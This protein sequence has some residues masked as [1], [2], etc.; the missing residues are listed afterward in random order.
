MVELRVG[1]SNLDQVIQ[2]LNDAK[3]NAYRYS[4]SVV[5]F[6]LTMAELTSQSQSIQ[7]AVDFAVR[8][9]DGI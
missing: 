4:A 6:R 2:E 5:R 9:G 3:I 7:K 8:E 1:E